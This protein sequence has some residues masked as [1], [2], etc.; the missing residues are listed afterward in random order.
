[1]TL[2]QSRPYYRG[3]TA[4]SHHN[5]QRFNSAPT[6]HSRSPRHEKVRRTKSDALVTSDTYRKATNHGTYKRQELRRTA[7]HNVYTS[8]SRSSSSRAQT[9]GSRRARER[10][11]IREQPTSSPSMAEFSSP[12]DMK[13][14][15]LLSEDTPANNGYVT[16]LLPEEGSA[17][18]RAEPQPGLSYFGYLSPKCRDI[19]TLNEM[20]K[21]EDVAQEAG[22]LFRH[23]QQ[24]SDGIGYSKVINPNTW[25]DCCTC[26]CC[27]KALFYHCSEDDSDD[28]HIDASI[29]P[30]SCQGPGAECAG[31][32]GILGVLSMC[33][34]CLLCYPLIQVANHMRRN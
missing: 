8:S 4:A 11:P 30:C 15:Q 20:W 22:E 17:L 25:V 6:Q 9:S 26:L 21:N 2:L 33:M 1:M 28:C 14:G 12:R 34:P 19:L 13:R 24:A 10:P 16:D 32:W 5:L 29:D 18:L 7:A 27:V 3:V 23:D 31:R